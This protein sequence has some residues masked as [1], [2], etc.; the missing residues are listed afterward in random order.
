MKKLLIIHLLFLSSWSLSCQDTLPTLNTGLRFSS[1]YNYRVLHHTP[2]IF[3]RN[4]SH[5]FYLGYQ[6]TTVLRSPGDGSDVYDRNARGVNLGY[7]YFFSCRQ[8]CPF[9]QF[10][11]GIY[12]LGYKEYQLGPPVATDRR[13]LLLENTLSMGLELRPFER[14]HLF[15]GAGFGSNSGLFVIPASIIPTC[16][17]G[18][19]Y[20]LK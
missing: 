6:W 7:R 1:V 14:I 9:I 13:V 4:G 10:A 15:A 3:L 18:M 19:G 20:S 2:G 16:F 12:Y 5:E 11:F 17:M 8:F